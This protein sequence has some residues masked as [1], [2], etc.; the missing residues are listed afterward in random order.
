M[1]ARWHEL[2]LDVTEG[3]DYSAMEA[4]WATATGLRIAPPST[5]G[6]PGDLVDHTGAGI[7]L[8]PVPEPKAAK[9]RVHLDVHTA[10]IASLIA[11]GATVVE[12]LERWTVLADPEGGELCAFGRPTV[13]DY[14]IYELCVDSVDSASI[15]AWWAQRF[16]VEA[17][18]EGQGWR[19]LEGVPGMPFEAWVFVDVPEPKTVKNR[20]HW[21]VFGDVAEFTAAGATLLWDMP[22]WSVLADPEG[23]EFCVFP[24]PPG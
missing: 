10:D 11:A 6:S 14:R 21:D 15:A 1:T 20:L 16:G 9:H 17:R 4:F 2:C 24:E 3:T 23:N 5:P 13:A 7:A 12:E 22:R 18:D 8:C 19:W